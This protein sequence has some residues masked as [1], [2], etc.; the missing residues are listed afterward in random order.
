MVEFFGISQ[1]ANNSNTQRGELTNKLYS[2][3]LPS[4]KIS[5]LVVNVVNIWLQYTTSASVGRVGSSKKRRNFCMMAIASNPAKERNA[6][7]KRAFF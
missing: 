3:P 4:T 7:A 1:Q 5:A 6:H 2:I